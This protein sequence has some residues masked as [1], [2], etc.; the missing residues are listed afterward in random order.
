MVNENL[1]DETRIALDNMIDELGR[2]PIG[3]PLLWLWVWDVVKYAYESYYPGAGEEL[4]INS[5]FTIDDVWNELWE[6]PVFSLDMGPE[7]LSE[8]VF[9]WLVEHDFIIDWEDPDMVD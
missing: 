6:R 1:G 3:M 4:V 9:D 5:K 8:H 2:M 7:G